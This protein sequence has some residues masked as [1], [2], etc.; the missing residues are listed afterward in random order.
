MHS[1]TSIQP[2]EQNDK[3]GAEMSKT[4]ALGKRNMATLGEV[5]SPSAYREQMC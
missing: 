4:Y 1:W 5:H 2:S 3:F